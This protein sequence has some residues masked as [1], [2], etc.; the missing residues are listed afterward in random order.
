[1][2]TEDTLEEAQDAGRYRRDDEVH[3]VDLRDNTALHVP[4]AHAELPERMQR[5]C[6]F[7]NADE[8]SLPFVHPVLR[9]ILLHFMIGYDHPFRRRQRTHGAR[10][11]LLVD[12]AE[13]ATG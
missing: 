2:L 5:L 7:A 4:P 8:A 6:D 9:A 1:M 13:P 12:G 10:A 3:V 11:V